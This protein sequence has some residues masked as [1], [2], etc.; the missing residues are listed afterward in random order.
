MVSIDY[1]HEVAYGCIEIAKS[2]HFGNVDPLQFTHSM[3][4]RAERVTKHISWLTKR[5]N[6]DGW[7]GLPDRFEILW[8]PDYCGRYD[9]VQFNKGSIIGITFLVLPANS[10]LP[11]IDKR[12]EVEA[13]VVQHE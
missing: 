13:F 5:I 12:Q 4:M 2:I 3:R 6:S 8:G 7:S 1:L 9:L 10:P 11:I